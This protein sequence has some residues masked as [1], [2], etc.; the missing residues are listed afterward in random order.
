MDIAQKEWL[1][2][3][4]CF[5]CFV[6]LACFFPHF[7]LFPFVVRV[8]CFFCLCILLPVG[9]V[10]LSRQSSNSSVKDLSCAGAIRAFA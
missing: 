10:A 2:I 8:F 6:V 3:V 7:P 4:R 1:C 5:A 9:S